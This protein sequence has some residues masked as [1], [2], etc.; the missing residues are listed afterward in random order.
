MIEITIL[1]G[2]G[3]TGK[4]SV[5][6]ALASVAKNSVFCDCDVDAA[7]MFLIFDPKTIE[8]H[9]FES[10]KKAQIN[11]EIC[12]KCGIC[13]TSCAFEAIQK[14]DNLFVVNQNLCEGCK[15]CE[16]LCPVKA[17]TINTFMKNKWYVTNSRFGKFL[18]AKMGVGEENSGRLVTILKEK[19]REIA[20]NENLNYMINDGPPGIG[21]PV[22]ASVSGTQK[23]LIITE[24]TLSGWHDAKRLLEIINRNKT[25]VFAVI[26]KYDLNLEIAKK[27]E[28]F[29]ITENIPLIGKIPFDKEIINAQIQQ[30]NIVEYNP[31]SKI[32]KIIKTIWENI[33]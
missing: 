26:N 28:E 13:K 5:T 27:A 17:I 29:F 25:E 33:K 23:V 30:K 16:K 2:K 31:D 18:W 14:I 10:S 22:I 9:A 7:D 11:I 6:T 20:Q 32:T 15:L 24:P 4:T 12:A 21:C 8:E 3:G 19:A 1:S